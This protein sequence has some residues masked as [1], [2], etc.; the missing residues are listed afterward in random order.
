[1]LQ[2]HGRVFDDLYL[3]EETLM[4]K[5]GILG[6][7]SEKGRRSYC[8]RK[9]LSILQCDSDAMIKIKKKKMTKQV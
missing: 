6:W 9:T 2:E 3:N 5:M 7:N 1:M 4:E 8:R